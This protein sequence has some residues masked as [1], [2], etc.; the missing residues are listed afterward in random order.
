MLTLHFYP[1]SSRNLTSVTVLY[2]L[3]WQ[4]SVNYLVVSTS[5]RNAVWN[6]DNNLPFPNIYAVLVAF[7][8]L[9]NLQ[10]RQRRWV[11][12]KFLR[13]KR[14]GLE[15]LIQL[16]RTDTSQDQLLFCIRLIGQCRVSV[17]PPDAKVATLLWLSSLKKMRRGSCTCVPYHR[18]SGENSRQVH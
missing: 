13:Q 6:D 12:A 9:R 16:Y 1:T 3:R 10:S 2:G 15:N 5:Q 18:K 7:R 14:D 4:L 17:I 8:A 11:T